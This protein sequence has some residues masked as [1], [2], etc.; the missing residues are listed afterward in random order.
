MGA[1]VG[2]RR[3]PAVDPDDT[4][5]LADEPDTPGDS[6]DLLGRRGDVPRSA[7]AQILVVHRGRAHRR[8]LASCHR[9][10]VAGR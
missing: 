7:Q 6:V 9:A 2:E 1:T 4:P 5:R 8:I 3:D 10:G